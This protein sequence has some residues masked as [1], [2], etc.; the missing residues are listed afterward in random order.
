M[1]KNIKGLV[2]MNCSYQ[3]ELCKFRNYS[4]SLVVMNGFCEKILIVTSFSVNKRNASKSVMI[5]VELP[6]IVTY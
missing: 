3:C 4:L 1:R 6:C 2:P 5:T